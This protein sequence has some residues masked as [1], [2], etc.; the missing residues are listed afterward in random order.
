M[1]APMLFTVGHSNHEMP[2]LLDLLRQ[3]GITLL[4]DV[5]S[6]PHSRYNSQFNREA[7]QAALENC[8]IGYVFLG[9][10]LG[11]RREER[12]CYLG[13]KVQYA[14]VARLPVFKQGLDYLREAVTRKRV[15]LLC[16][17]K[18]PLACHRTILIC[19]QLRSDDI[20]ISHIRD[21]GTV[22]THAEAE[23]RLLALMNMPS[24]SLF[25]SKEEL[26]EE[27]YDRQGERIAFVESPE[28][29]GEPAEL[30]Y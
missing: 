6:S 10:E 1:N 23:N 19:R 18:D 26:I 21:D 5:R 30:S 15:A 27:A 22:E 28:R 9:R 7:L 4:A 29:E 13:P 20:S 16:A 25:Q 17:E 8:G 14:R 12:E 24:G 11:A 3:H 2:A